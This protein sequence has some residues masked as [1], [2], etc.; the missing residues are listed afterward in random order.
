VGRYDY[1]K[2]TPLTRIT[3]SWMNS[4]VDALNELASVVFAPIARMAV[5]EVAVT[6]GTSGS[7][8]SPVT[9]SPPTGRGW[10]PVMVRVLWGGTFAPGE[11]VSV[12]LVVRFTDGTTA[13]MILSSSATGER[14][15]TDSE[16]ASLWK[17][18]VSVDQVAVSATSNYPSTYVS[19]S[20]TIYAVES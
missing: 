17:D 4:V 9:L 6:P 7:Y 14:W 18:G 8:G 3:T 2:V 16:K 11:E 19:V 12:R 13:S 5:K 15:L 1:L 10:I 20:V